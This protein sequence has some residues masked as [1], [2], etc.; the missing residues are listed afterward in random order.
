MRV[1]LFKRNS[2]NPI[3]TAKDWPY[4]VHSVFNAAVA[5]YKDETILLARCE[6]YRGISHLTVARS[7]N[8]VDRWKI[9][10]SPTIVGEPERFKEEVWGIEDPRMTYVE[11][12]NYR[13]YLNGYV[14]AIRGYLDGKPV[15]VISV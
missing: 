4:E 1:K 11:E 5:R 15:N 2:Q 9:D 12:E 13:A 6:D 3:L 7:R 8:G 10:P 14:A